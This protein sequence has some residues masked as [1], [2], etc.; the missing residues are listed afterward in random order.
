LILNASACDGDTRGEATLPPIHPT[1]TKRGAT[2][3]K[4]ILTTVLA[5]LKG[6]KTYIAAAGLAGLG[7]YQL[8]I[9]DVAGLQTLAPGARRRR[10]AG[11]RARSSRRDPTIRRPSDH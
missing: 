8:S 6:K 5:K 1:I 11:R 2:V 7:V 10:A 3:A 9:G 4:L